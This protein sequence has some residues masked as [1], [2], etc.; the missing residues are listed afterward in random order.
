VTRRRHDRHQG[1]RDGDDWSTVSRAGHYGTDT[2][3]GSPEVKITAL[4][5]YNTRHD[6]SGIVVELHGDMD[7]ATAPQLLDVLQDALNRDDAVTVD[8]GAVDFID[9][10]GVGALVAADSYGTAKGA[11]LA[12]CGLSEPAKRT[13]QI[14]GLDATLTVRT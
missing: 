10:S 2:S 3:H 11:R 6:G 4:L 1:R 9:S 12:L 13:I 5:S 14:L 7:L 8:L